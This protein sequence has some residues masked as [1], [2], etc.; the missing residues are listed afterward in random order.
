MSTRFAG[1][2]TGAKKPRHGITYN[3]LPGRQNRTAGIHAFVKIEIVRGTQ[4]RTSTGQQFWL[5]CLVAGISVD[6]YGRD[7]VVPDA[8]YGELQYSVFQGETN[9]LLAAQEFDGFHLHAFRQFN[10]C[11]L[12]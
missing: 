3:D 6:R 12:G 8:R 7:L 11:S 9:T 4:P 1:Q 5:R 2:A 10:P